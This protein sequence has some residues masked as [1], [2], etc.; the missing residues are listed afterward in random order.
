VATRSGYV[1]KRMAV[2]AASTSGVVIGLAAVGV[3]GDTMMD[4]DGNVYRTVT[5][6]TQV[7]MKENLKTTRYRDGT[8]IACVTGNSAWAALTTPAYCYYNNDS[9]GNKATYGALYNWH[10][11]DPANPRQIAPAGWHVPTAADWA[12]LADR[13]G[14]EYVAGGKMKEAGTAHWQAPNTNATNSSGF[15]ALPGGYRSDIGLCEGMGYASYGNF[16]YWWSSTPDVGPPSWSRAV[17]SQEAAMYSG[18]VLGVHAGFSI[19]CVR[20]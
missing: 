3:T 1:T 14:G 7:W 18:H 19:R 8:P 13:L 16:G 2:S 20:D 11:V 15:T 4:I 12:T 6:G 9:A 17:R 5:I 10:V